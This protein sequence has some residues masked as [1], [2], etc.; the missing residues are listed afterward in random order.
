VTTLADFGDR[1]WLQALAAVLVGLLLAGGAAHRT[2]SLEVPGPLRPFNAALGQAGCALL[3]GA[4]AGATA[5]MPA[6]HG[7]RE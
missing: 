1:Q 5:I 6:R 3:G 7:R 4:L 2:G